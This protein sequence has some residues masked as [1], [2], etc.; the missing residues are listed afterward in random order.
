EQP[1]LRSGSTLS[2]LAALRKLGLVS[3]AEHQDLERAYVF[4]RRVADA[5]RMVRGHAGDLLLPEEDSEELRFLARR[6]GYGGSDW[7]EGARSLLKDV[8]LHRERVASFFDRHFRGGEK[9]R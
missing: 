9:I 6:L 3:E 2:A 1:E 4:W 5:L 8:R 7:E